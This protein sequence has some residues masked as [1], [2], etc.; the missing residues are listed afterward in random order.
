[1]TLGIRVV[2]SFSE[3]GEISPLRIRISHNERTYVY[4]VKESTSTAPANPM[5]VNSISYHYIVQ[6]EGTKRERELSIEYNTR[7]HS[8]RATVNNSLFSK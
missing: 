1:M 7:M 3:T 5:W 8:W 4:N 2:A 6:Q